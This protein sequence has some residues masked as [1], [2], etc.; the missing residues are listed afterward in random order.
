MKRI[1]F[2]F[3]LLLQFVYSS[4]EAN[5]LLGGELSY[6]HIAAD[7]YLLELILY[8]DCSSTSG[9]L[10]GLYNSQPALI[11]KRRVGAS[12]QNYDTILLTVQQ[13]VGEEITPLCPSELGNSTCN[14]GTLPGISRFVYRS[15]YNLPSASQGNNKEWSFEFHGIQNYNPA[16]SAGRSNLITNLTFA[17]SGLSSIM[18]LRAYLNRNFGENSSPGFTAVPTPFYCINKPQ[19]YNLGAVDGDNDAL[20]YALVPGLTNDGTGSTNYLSG[21]SATAPLAVSSPIA[22]NPT[23]GQMDFTPNT[24]QNSVVVYEA[25]ERR[26]GQVIGTSMREMTFVVLNNCNNDPPAATLSAGQNSIVSGDQITA[27]PGTPI[28]ALLNLTD[29]NGNNVNVSYSNLP[30]GAT[31]TINNNNTLNPTALFSWPNPVVGFYTFFVT[32]EDDGC[33]LAVRQTRAYTV[34]IIDVQNPTI[35]FLSP[36]DCDHKATVRF[37]FPDISDYGPIIATVRDASGAVVATYATSSPSQVDSFDVGTYTI[38]AAHDPLGCSSNPVTFSINH[39]GTYPYPPD[40]TSP[41]FYCRGDVAVP[42]QATSS[43]PHSPTSFSWYLNGAPIA[44][45]PTPSTNTLGIQSYSVTQSYLVCESDP[46]FIQVY[47]SDPPG[48]DFIFDQPICQYDTV[49]VK[50]Q[51][52]YVDSNGVDITW[53]FG[54]GVVVDSGSVFGEVYVTFPYAGNYQIGIDQV[55][56]YQCPG[57]PRKKFLRVT[58]STLTR[59]FGDSVGCQYEPITV[60]N[61]IIPS[62][63]TTYTWEAGPDATITNQNK[64]NATVVFSTPG[65]KFVRLTAS[66]DSCSYVQ[67]H[68]IN[69]YPKPNIELTYKNEEFCLG[70]TISMSVDSGVKLTFEPDVFVKQDQE[71]PNVYYLV[72]FKPENFTIYAEGEGGCLD[73]AYVTVDNIKDCCNFFVPNAFTPNNDG[74]NDEFSVWFEG[75]PKSFKLQIFNRWGQSVFQS[76]NKYHTWDGTYNGREVDMGVYF[77]LLEGECY[78]RESPLQES[79]DVTLIR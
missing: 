76:L 71:E 13:P 66:N 63:T 61:T 15:N 46:K 45:P 55:S 4:T 52:P 1:F 11:I 8:A 16:Y 68:Y 6:K 69:I 47:V 42:L 9:A 29:P 50:Y 24:I 26:N 22:F 35:D 73:T 79:G 37:N 28:Q 39:S 57:T 58:P 31:L 40:V 51:G 23:S 10:T 70:D 5:H 14:G 75:N 17:S 21:Y 78:E 67:T 27:C 62:P 64:A 60:S 77:Y 19:T 74:R 53:D 20:T 43:A 44:G 33:P 34:K 59:L 72:I 54:L 38:T 36:S 3:L 65:Q 56:E 41:V 48:N 2:T 12:F 30:S 18:N 32:M 25:T 7:S 49:L